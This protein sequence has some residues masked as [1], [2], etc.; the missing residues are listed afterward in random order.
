[1]EHLLDKGE[2]PDRFT[3]RVAF[4]GLLG[5]L[6]VAIVIMVDV[7]LR[8]I[9]LAPIMGFEEVASLLYAVVVATCFPAGLIQGHNITIRFLGKGL[10]P[11]IELWLESFGTLLTLVFF[12][13]VAWQIGDV[14]YDEMIH[15]RTTLTL[16]MPTAPW[17]WVVATVL[18]LCLPVQVM[19]T[20]IAFV[21]AATGRI[22]EIAEHEE[23]PDFLAG[24][25]ID[26]DDFPS[27]RG[28]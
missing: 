18:T 7:L 10:G 17:W 6:S 5:L 1:M 12:F 15:D 9:F 19:V 13:L 11:R 8:W 28:V 3:R 23:V 20:V 4:I 21:R 2:W 14:A 26:L 24:I 27:G 22:P 16:R 25:D